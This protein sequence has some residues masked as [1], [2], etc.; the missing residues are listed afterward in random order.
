MEHHQTSRSAQVR[1]SSGLLT[2]V[3]QTALDEQGWVVG[4]EGPLVA[5]AAPADVL[6]VR[7]HARQCREAVQA[8]CRGEIGGA[9]TIDELDALGAALDAWR[10]RLLV[11]STA[12]S[13]TVEPLRDL[14]TRQLQVLEGVTVG[15]RNAE[16]SAAFHISIPSVKREITAL[17]RSTGA[18]SR[19]ALAAAGH[20]LGFGADTA[21]D[22]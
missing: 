15:L 1:V 11:V 8:L 7:P 19:G 4:G 13:T 18:T 20:R 21:S 12:V 14:T 2:R 6:L 17:Q 22:M 10:A 9:I 16:I 3:V 5:D